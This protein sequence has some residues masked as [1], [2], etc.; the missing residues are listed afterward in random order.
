MRI[1]WYSCGK[2]IFKDCRDHDNFLE[3][4]GTIFNQII[5]SLL[6]YL[7][8][9]RDST[10]FH[11]PSTDSIRLT[12]DAIERLQKIRYFLLKHPDEELIIEGYG[13]SSKDYRYNEN[14]SELR[15]S[16]VKGYLEKLGI[17]SSRL[18]TFWMG[19]ENPSGD[20]DPQKKADKDHQVEI[21]LKS[22]LESKQKNWI[23]LLD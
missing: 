9:C 11:P 20:T 5:H 6:P 7:A 16:V 13:D 3:R 10:R 2:A 22:K 17:S 4:L 18:Q 23:D 15:A 21:S 19:F 14:L 8:W 12:D 1:P